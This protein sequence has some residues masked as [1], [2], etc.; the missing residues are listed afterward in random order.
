MTARKGPLGGRSQIDVGEY[1]R[2]TYVLAIATK[3]N[4]DLAATLPPELGIVVRRC[5]RGR[6]HAASQELAAI[7]IAA[8]I[9]SVV[10]PSAT[11]FGRNDVVYIPNAASA[12]VVVRNRDEV[13]AALRRRQPGTRH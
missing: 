8:G 5:L 2:M 7:W 11:G 6:T 4:L 10:F 3:K 13:V 9:D 12:S 1:P